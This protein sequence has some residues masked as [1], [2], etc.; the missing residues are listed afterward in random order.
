MVGYN[1]VE[2][3]KQ[4]SIFAVNFENVTGGVLD[5]NDAIPVA[6]QMTRGRSDSD[7]DTVMVMQNDG[8]YVSYYVSDGIVKQ[9]GKEQPYNAALDGKWLKV[10]SS[11]IAAV[12]LNP[13]VS[14]WYKATN[15]ETP[16]SLSIAGAVPSDATKT[17]EINKSYSLISNPYPF[18]LDVN[19]ISYVDG[20]TKGRSDTDADTI[21][22]MQA[23]GGYLNYYLSDGIVKQKGKEQPYNAALDGKWLKVGSSAV[24]AAAIPTGKGAFYKRTG[25]TDFSIVIDSP[26]AK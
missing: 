18:D 11:A 4:F 5:L 15:Y 20:M 26:I 21:M 9:K 6:E 14:F 12:P 23:D 1:T 2:V 10:G 7:A 3:N 24:A 25:E 17:I 13:G 22:I 19:A 16:W 8:G